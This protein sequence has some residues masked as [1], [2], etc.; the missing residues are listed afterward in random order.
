M[1]KRNSSLGFG[2]FVVLP[3]AVITVCLFWLNMGILAPVAAV[4]LV[5]PL[6]LFGLGVYQWVE[7][8]KEAWAKRRAGK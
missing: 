6:Y 5:I 4:V 1:K 7:E 3:V 8:L 2:R